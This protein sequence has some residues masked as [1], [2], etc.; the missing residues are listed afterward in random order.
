[1]FTAVL[2]MVS[3]VWLTL[4]NPVDC[5]LPGSSVHG[6]SKA[7]I[8]EWVA[9]SYS[10]A[11][12]Q[13]RDQTCISCIFWIGRWI[14]YHYTT[15]KQIIAFTDAQIASCWPVRLSSIWLLS[16]F[17]T[18]LV[19]YLYREKANHKSKLLSASDQSAIKQRFPWPPPHS[20][21]LF[22]RAAHRTQ[23]NTEG[24][25]FKFEDMV[26]RYSEQSEE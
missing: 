13:P 11:S 15:Q 19:V 2:C 18:T 12:T 24:Y 20:I 4:C 14:I 22:V 9:I 26:K 8:L 7:R 25:Q 17:G 6:I 3:H 5:S 16:P 21:L 23:G 10:K 1:M